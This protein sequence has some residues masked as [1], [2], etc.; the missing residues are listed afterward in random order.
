[1]KYSQ[2]MYSLPILDF[3]QKLLL[4]AL[5]VAAGAWLLKSEVILINIAGILLLGLMYCHAQILQHECLHGTAFKSKKMNTVVGVILGMPMLVSFS[6]YRVSHLR[7]HAYLG[8]PRDQ[9]F[10]GYHSLEEIRIRQLLLDLF[11]F[12]RIKCCFKNMATVLGYYEADPKLFTS[13][14]KS[15]YFLMIFLLLVALVSSFAFHSAVLLKFWILPVILVA[16][17]VYFLIELPEHLFC[18]KTTQDF[19]RNTRNIKGSW[20]SFWLTNGNNFHVEHHKNAGLATE[21]FPAKFL[22][23]RESN[24]KYLEKSYPE[25]YLKVLS[26]H[27]FKERIS[28]KKAEV[29][30]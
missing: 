16:E 12:S 7:H 24:Y 21:H 3:R 20:F 6:H 10:F 26:T 11:G 2:P 28:I 14:A 13:Q 15:E 5:I 27:V 30:L 29:K 25:F 9:E 1:M 17:P 23:T 8:T 22:K 4:M 19:Y 18:D